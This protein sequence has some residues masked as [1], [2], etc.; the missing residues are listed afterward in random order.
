[1]RVSHTSI[2]TPL[3]ATRTPI[4]RD[5][6]GDHQP[7]L[8]HYRAEAIQSSIG[9][10][11]QHGGLRSSRAESLL[12]R[13]LSAYPTVPIGCLHLRSL[14]IKVIAE[15]RQGREPESWISVRGRLVDHLQWW[16]K[17][18][19]MSVGMSFRPVEPEVVVFTDA[20]TSGWGVSCDAQSWQG[21]WHRPGLYINWLEMRTVLVALQILQFRLLRREVRIWIDKSTTVAYLRKEGGRRSQA[22]LRLSHRI[23]KL[24]YDLQIH[25]YPQ[26]I[27]GHLNVLA[28]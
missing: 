1:M 26:H 10:A 7:I 2:D 9:A 18:D 27:A 3:Y 12:G 23:L 15:V 13:L 6:V 25:V 4:Q 11:I 16:L 17:E 22:L 5:K 14:Q 28:D 24:A 19:V 20:S 8:S 21:K